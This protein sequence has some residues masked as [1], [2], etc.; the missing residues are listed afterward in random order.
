MK[1]AELKKKTEKEWKYLCCFLS[2]FISWKSMRLV[3][4]PRQLS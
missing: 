3:L 2:F 1:C 4:M